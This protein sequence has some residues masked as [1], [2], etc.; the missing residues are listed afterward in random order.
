D[1][2]MMGGEGASSVNLDDA[3]LRLYRPEFSRLTKSL[4]EVGFTSAIELL[5]TYTGRAVDL[6]P[7]LNDAEINRDRNLRLQYTAGS[8]LNL[9]EGLTIY[10][11]MVAYRNFPADVFLGTKALN[12]EL[13]RA[14]GR[15]K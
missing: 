6:M 5:S 8:E 3:D 15:R 1:L 14:I 12:D 2:V 4:Q 7:W 9:D 13:K 10:Q 11:E